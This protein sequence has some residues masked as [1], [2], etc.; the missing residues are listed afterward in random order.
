MTEKFSQLATNIPLDNDPNKQYLV[1]NGYPVVLSFA[2][3]ANTETLSASVT[4]CL[5][6]VI[7][8][9]QA[10]RYGRNTRYT[11]Y[12]RWKRC[13]GQPGNCSQMFFDN[14]III[15]LTERK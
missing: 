11:L 13:S 2:K 12:W 14:R 9:K 15:H 3:E 1:I 10:E 5:Q 8:R 7:R 6:Q 4:S